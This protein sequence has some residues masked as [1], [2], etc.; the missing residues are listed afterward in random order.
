MSCPFTFP[1]PQCHSPGVS[2]ISHDT[3]VGQAQAA[4][5]HGRSEL[6]QVLQG[7]AIELCVCV[8]GGGAAEQPLALISR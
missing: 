6:R 1:A 5:T 7:V 8:G 2:C 3:H 4:Q